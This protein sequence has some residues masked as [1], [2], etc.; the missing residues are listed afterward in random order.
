[1]TV[2]P[3]PSRFEA[4]TLTSEFVQHL[5]SL[6]HKAYAIAPGL[7]SRFCEAVYPDPKKRGMSVDISV[8]TPMARFHVFM[9]M[10]IGMKVRIKDTPESTNSLL[11]TCYELAMQQASSTTF[12][13][14]NG[15]IEA[16]QLLS[17]FASIR[18]EPFAPKPLQPSF[19]W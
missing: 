9:A 16:A 2:T 13:Q 12:W 15:G 18:K 19:S 7:F 4:E 11:D 10:A 1:M 14:E 17:I 8:S 6:E 3:F 5:E